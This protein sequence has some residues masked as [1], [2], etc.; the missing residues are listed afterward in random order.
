MRL[1]VKLALALAPLSLTACGGPSNHI[2][3]VDMTGVDPG[4]HSQDLAACDHERSTGQNGFIEIG[5]PIANCM[6]RKGY[7][8]LVNG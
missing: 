3:I 5:N 8:V 2:P 4:R 6:R 7:K 1:S